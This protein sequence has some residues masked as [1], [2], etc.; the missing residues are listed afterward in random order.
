MSDDPAARFAKEF[1]VFPA[2]LRSL[3]EE[4]VRAGNEIVEIGSGDPSPFRGSTARLARPVTTRPRSGADGIGFI[5][6]CGSSHSGEFF[7]PER[8]FFVLE[9]PKEYVPPDMDAIREERNARE[10]A[11]NADRF[12]SGGW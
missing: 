6:R 10:R 1:A 9:P 7:D 8:L 11:A 5:E 12:A 2:G 3:L 4:E